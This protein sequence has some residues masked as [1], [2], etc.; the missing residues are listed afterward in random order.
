MAMYV[1]FFLLGFVVCAII[2]I[3]LVDRNLFSISH[4]LDTF[5]QQTT[6]SLANMNNP[7]INSL[8]NQATTTARSSGIDEGLHIALLAMYK[9][10]E[11][12]ELVDYNAMAESVIKIVQDFGNS[13]KEYTKWNKKYQ[14]YR[15]DNGLDGEDEDDED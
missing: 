2:G 10:W 7:A 11:D 3:V 14:K 4:K 8:V 9:M 6:M 5:S 1:A 12:G 13:A 15:T